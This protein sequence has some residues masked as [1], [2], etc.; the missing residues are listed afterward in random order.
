MDTPC[1]IWP[2]AKSASGYGA[3]RRGGHTLRV[4]RVAWEEAYGPI[5]DGMLV[6]HHCDTPACYELTHLFLGTQ[7]DNM[8]DCFA[9]GRGRSNL[10]AHPRHSHKLTPDQVRE[11][12]ATVRPN[13]VGVAGGIGAAARRYGVDAETVRDIVKGRSWTSVR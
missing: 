13:P 5:P 10:P 1:K 9:K 8:R 11:I 6:C 4:H 2:G 12:R 7:S 3:I